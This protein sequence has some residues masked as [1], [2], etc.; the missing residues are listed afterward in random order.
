MRKAVKNA[1]L[2]A[3]KSF[4]DKTRTGLQAEFDYLLLD[5]QSVVCEEGEVSESRRYPDTASLVQL[6]VEG[7]TQALE[8]HHGIILQLKERPG[9]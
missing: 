5:I 9:S 2:D 8:S 7:L 4:L 3:V 1:Q 6:Q